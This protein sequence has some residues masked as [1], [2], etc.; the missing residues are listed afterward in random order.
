ML[1]DENEDELLDCFFCKKEH[2]NQDVFGF[3]GFDEEDIEDAGLTK[4]FQKHPNILEDK[5]DICGNCLNKYA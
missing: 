5:E 3:I 4:F 1:M 2:H